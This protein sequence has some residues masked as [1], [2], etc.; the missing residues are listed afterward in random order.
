M[1]GK[2]FFWMCSAAGV[3]ALVTGNTAELG[4]AVLEGCRRSAELSFSL[5]GMM[6]LWCGVL[7][8]LKSAGALGV[9]ARILTPLLRR[10]FPESGEDEDIMSD[11]AG[12][13]AAN[14]LGVASA[15][16]PYA[17]S[18]MEK[19]DKKNGMSASASGDM[20]TL[21]L[22]GCNSVSLFPTT[23]ITLLHGAGSRDPYKII[24]PVWICSAICTSFSLLLARL[25]DIRRARR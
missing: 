13:V 11:V 24:V 1:L 3:C 18:A 9:L 16:T 7:E 25:T 21:S 6:C 19:L 23:I 15:A 5:L 22:L 8:V 20:V 2:C 17:L 10:I 4:D 12:S 14:M